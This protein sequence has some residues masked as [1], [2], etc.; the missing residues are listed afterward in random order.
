[1]QIADGVDDATWEFHLR[2]GDIAGWLRQMIKNPELADEVIAIERAGGA[3]S[4]SRTAVRAAIE[5]RYTLPVD[6]AS[7]DQSR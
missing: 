1:M 5:K 2:N 4:E 3:P 7:G 6:E